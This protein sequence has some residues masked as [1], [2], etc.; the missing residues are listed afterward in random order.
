MHGPTARCCSII[1]TFAVCAQIVITSNIDTQ[2]AH[3][4][5]ALISF[6]LKVRVWLGGLVCWDAHGW[7]EGWLCG[8]PSSNWVCVGVWVG[9]CLVGKWV[10]GCGVVRAA[11]VGTCAK[12]AGAQ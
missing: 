12:G 4:P 10:G 8:S 1:F 11:G 7:F 2:L 3:V 9:G 6:V 5:E